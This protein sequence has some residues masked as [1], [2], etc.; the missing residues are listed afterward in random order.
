MAN[1]DRSGMTQAGIN[2]MGKAVGG[3]TIQFTKLVLGDGTMTGEILDLQGVVS[4]K[5]NVDVTRIERNDNQCTVGGELLTSSVKQGFFWREC[6]LY[7]MDPDVGEI[8]YNYAYSTK[9]DY[10]VASDS[11]MMEEILVSMIAIVGSNANVDITI[12]SSMVFATKKETIKLQEEIDSIVQLN[13]KKFGAMTDGTD[14]KD[15]FIRMCEYIN[16]NPSIKEIFFPSGIYTYSDGLYFSHEVKLTGNATLNYTGTGKAI[17]FGKRDLT[18]QNYQLDF[19]VNGLTFTG[20]MNMS[21][22]LFFNRFTTMVRLIGVKF[23]N[24]GHA[25]SYAIWLD[26]DNWDTFINDLSWHSDTDYKQ[27]LMYIDS[28]NINST[29]VRL[30]NSVLTNQS[31]VRGSGVYI[32]GACSEITNCKIEGFNP[33]IELSKWSYGTTISNC[34]FEYTDNDACIVLGDE[35]S[36]YISNIIFKDIYC[37]LHHID[38]GCT[39]SFI[40]P[41]SSK[42][43][44][45]NLLLDTINFSSVSQELPIIIL[46]DLA[47]QTGNKAYNLHGFYKFRNSSPK[48][49]QWEGIEYR[50]EKCLIVRNNEDELNYIEIQTGETANQYQG[51]V[52]KGYDGTELFTL[53]TAP[54][55]RAYIKKGSH[56]IF[57]ISNGGAIGVGKP[58]SGEKFEVLGAVSADKLILPVKVDGATVYNGTLFFDSDGKLKF[59]DLSGTLKVISTV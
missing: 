6:G 16:E 18:I 27:N 39:G 28:K 54:D 14:N 44:F 5:Q 12:D 36:N 41:K 7:A 25:T 11:G 15:V 58:S 32:D 1:F 29:R 48:A 43:G 37:N 19:E 22:G 20:G 55:G 50:K 51:V 24:F 23:R 26:G 10:I 17:E 45:Q 49:A 52:L 2:L 46:N 47:S 8:L 30:N 4:P 53:E 38:L 33:N 57:N 56:V 3:A 9:P 35:T 34:Y 59:R 21:H 40:R 42:S 31:K 13:V